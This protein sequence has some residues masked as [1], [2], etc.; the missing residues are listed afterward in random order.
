MMSLIGTHITS[1]KADHHGIVLTMSDGQVEHTL[2]IT[3]DMATMPDEALL[4]WSER[5]EPLPHFAPLDALTG[6]ELRLG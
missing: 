5:V 1:I 4:F 2:T 3:P 6:E